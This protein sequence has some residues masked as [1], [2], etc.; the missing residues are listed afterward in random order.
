MTV[1]II[2]LRLFF[3]FIWNFLQPPSCLLLGYYGVGNVHCLECYLIS[4]VAKTKNKTIENDIKL[5][6][7]N[8]YFSCG[9]ME[10]L[11][12]AEQFEIAKIT[13]GQ[14]TR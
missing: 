6:T 11:G 10:V 12:F 5:S 13:L 3:T 4:V 1:R 8:L 2:F 14:T 9:Q 7:K